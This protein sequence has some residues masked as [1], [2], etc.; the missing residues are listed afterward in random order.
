MFN[1]FCYSLKSLHLDINESAN[2]SMKESFEKGFRLRKLRHQVRLF[3]NLT[4]ITGRIN[5]PYESVDFFEQFARNVLLNLWNQPEILWLPNVSEDQCEDI[6]RVK[7]LSL[8]SFQTYEIPDSMN[9]NVQLK[10]LRT[11]DPSF[12]NKFCL[13]FEFLTEV[14]CCYDPEASLALVI[15]G[16]RTQ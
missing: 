5:T 11:T 13:K 14:S 2:V 10:H 7:T 9:Q 6:N 1:S 15:F 4:S 8:K 12:L 3:E 16:I